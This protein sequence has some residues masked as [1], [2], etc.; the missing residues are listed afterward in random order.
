MDTKSPPLAH[1]FATL[2][3]Q[4]ET[5]TLGMWMFLVTEL[6]LFG[7]L[8]LAYTVYRVRNPAEF[9]IASKHLNIWFGGINTVVLLTSSLTMA[10]GVYWAQTGKRN[11]LTVGL[12]L[13]AL[14][15]VTF[16][17][18]KGFEYY[19]D[20]VENLMPGLA[21]DD[22]EWHELGVR[23]ERVKMFLIIYYMMTGIHALHLI[24]GIAII[25]LLAFWAH[26][27]HYTPAYYYPIEVGGL[28]WHFVDV[29]WVF[30]LPL[31]YLA[32]V[33]H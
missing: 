27:G 7:G 30:L 9:A 3:Q 12:V 33:R 17:V 1:H 10:L 26:R 24:I 13:T 25:G 15:G 8:F 29:I 32:G 4:H 22:A 5:A 18:I 14:L 11:L 21:F 31:L 23:P 28:Y 20:Y 19:G 6:M 2:K 16:L